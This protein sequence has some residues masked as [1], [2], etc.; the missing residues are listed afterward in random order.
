[1]TYITSNQFC[2]SLNQESYL[3]SNKED[4]L[5]VSFVCDSQ[6]YVLRICMRPHVVFEMDKFK[7]T[8]TRKM[9]MKGGSDDDVK[10][11]SG[12]INYN[13]FNVTINATN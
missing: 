10:F 12:V 8:A 7:N 6:I 2:I 11:E 1:M 4:M 5:A 3:S 13:Q 9:A